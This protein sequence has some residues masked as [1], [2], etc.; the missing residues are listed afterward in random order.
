MQDWTDRGEEKSLIIVRILILVRNVLHIPADTDL[1]RRPDNDASTHDQV[2][3]CYYKCS[4][5]FNEYKKKSFSLFIFF[6]LHKN[7][8]FLLFPRQSDIQSEI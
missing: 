3:L 1:E 4:I 5:V 2:R 8:L 7:L 6:I